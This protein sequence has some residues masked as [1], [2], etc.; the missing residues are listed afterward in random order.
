MEA[1]DSTDNKAQVQCD[2]VP[3]SVGGSDRFHD[4][5]EPENLCA[6]SGCTNQGLHFAAQTVSDPVCLVFAHTIG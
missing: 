5:I 4:H 2:I 6:V 3:D 1:N